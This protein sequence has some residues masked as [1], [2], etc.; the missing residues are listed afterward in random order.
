MILI[1]YVG[2]KQDGEI[3]DLTLEE[4]AK[5]EGLFNKDVD[6]SPIPV[7]VGHGYV[8]DGLDEE[9]QDME[10]GD[11]KEVEIT[12]EKAY[13]DRDSEKIQTYPEKEFKKQ[14][15]QVRPG[16]EL[17][18]GNQRGKV[19]SNSSG[20]VRIDF[21]HPLSGKDLDYWVKVV[22]K[23]EDEEE[24]IDNIIEFR[25]GHGEA[26]FEEEKVTIVHE[27]DGDHE[28]KLPEEVKNNIEEEIL[29]AT[30]YEEVEFQE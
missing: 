9:L 4:K 10:V 18:I 15:I 16:E 3:F 20:R 30:N 23:V 21:N 8:I 2:K 17:M 28:H 25:I 5:E 29:E 22:E 14:G 26:E 6:Y 24:I 11:E 27:H 1:D 19:L 13:G 7:L 12:S